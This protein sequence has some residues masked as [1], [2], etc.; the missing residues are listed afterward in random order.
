MKKQFT[1]LLL[2]LAF[3]FLL[4][5]C[6]NS[7]SDSN[8]TTPKEQPAGWSSTSTGV[9]YD[10]SERECFY[11]T[12]DTLTNQDF[13]YVTDVSFEKADR[14]IA[15]LVFQSSE[16][17]KDCYV[18]KVDART[19]KASLYK[20]EHGLEMALGVDVKVEDKTGYHLQVNM[21]GT[22]IDFFVDN[23][24]VCGTG[25][26]VVSPDLGQGDALLSGRLGLLGGTGAAT[27]QNTGY[28]VYDEGKAPVLSELSIQPAS[29]ST[30][31]PGNMLTNSWYVY[32]QYVSHDCSEISVQYAAPEG[33]DVTVLNSATGETVTGP[34][35]LAEG[36]NRFQLLTSVKGE[37]GTPTYQ[38]SY[39]L[40]VLRRGEGYYEEPYRGQYH[41]SV[42][43]GWANDPNGL[44][45]WGDTWH[46]Y[47]QFNPESTDWG[48][49]QWVHTTSKD[50]I[51]WEDQG[52]VLRPN[53]YGTMF[54]GYIVPDEDN[55]SGLFPDGQG[56]LVAIIT[57]NG[58]GQRMIAAY[59]QD[60]QNWT[61]YR[62]T[63]ENGALNGD[64]VLIDWFDDELLNQ[65]FR[66]PQIFKYQDTYFMTI[67]GGK[68]RIYSSTNLLDWKLES[69]YGDRPNN[70]SN[71]T[72]DTECPGLYRLPVEGEDSWKWIFSYGGRKY[73]VG[74][75]EQ[76]NGKWEFLPDADYA[77]PA[78]MNFGN[79]SYAALPYYISPSF[80]EDAQDRVIVC[81]W[82]N[83]WDY[84][85]L[86]D[87]FSGNTRFNGTYNLNLEAS[88]VRDQDGRLVLK[89]K[90]LDEYAQ[91]VFPAE[92]VKVDTV[93]AV[94]AGEAKKLEG[95]EGRSY[96]LDVT[97]TPDSSAVQAGVTVCTGE[98]LGTSVTYD[99]ATDTLTVNRGGSNGPFSSN[100]FSQVVTEKR[101]DGAVTLHIYVD[102]ASVEVF[103]G[104]YTAACGLQIFPGE[105]D[106]GIALTS[107]GGG[108]SFAV[109]VT[110]ASSIW[111]V[112]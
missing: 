34:V 64:D 32:Q 85:T 10:G 87:D 70:S 45:K 112:E 76:V 61:Y 55:V 21:I 41:Y 74:E 1:H 38:A 101:E 3:T 71:M 30:E 58:N 65:A 52:I 50:L 108:S 43:E 11:I 67:A 19:N 13:Q 105:A 68:L 111:S 63:D 92:N 31:A 16:D 35:S 17:S 51:H 84:C 78:T 48:N 96:L 88:L 86:V 66:D 73:Q 62:G 9:A 5:G 95:Y 29:G 82:M 109:T 24:L 4:A 104:G 54:N 103:S 57:A 100:S 107:E 8:L 12:E 27:F 53:E 28:Q 102:R 93:S 77:E 80:N 26:Y 97:I 60:G 6:N 46:M 91:Y 42:K 75:F 99:F 7:S 79:D 47:Y 106:T 56:G 59:S 2:M 18:A 110:E 44:V 83:S 89:Q 14:G 69:S 36:E 90:P 94:A 98:A 37:D 15:A 49:M 39:R 20:M 33:V 72:I 23:A 25:D 81:N 40:N 22:H